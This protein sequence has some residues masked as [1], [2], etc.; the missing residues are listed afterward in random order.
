MT[1]FLLKAIAMG[2]VL[3]VAVG[4]ES[5]AKIVSFEKGDDFTN[6][7]AEAG[8]VIDA[9]DFVKVSAGVVTISKVVSTSFL[10]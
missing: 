6:K 1:S 7:V 8:V 2:P 10:Q 4:T 3:L 9:G 5:A